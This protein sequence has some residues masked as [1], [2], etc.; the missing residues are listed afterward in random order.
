[1]CDHDFK[2]VARLEES[3]LDVL[4]VV[5]CSKCCFHA[6]VRN[7]VIVPQFDHYKG[8]NND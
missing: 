3:I 1:M 4:Y 5:K 8:E 6:E 2:Y 7:N